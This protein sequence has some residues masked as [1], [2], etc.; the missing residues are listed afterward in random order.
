MTKKIKQKILMK[1]TGIKSEWMARWVAQLQWAT[2][3]I[4]GKTSLAESL[5]VG[6]IAGSAPLLAEEVVRTK[7]IKE[8]H[9]FLT[10]RIYYLNKGR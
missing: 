9:Q 2:S 5:T 7:D 3:F 1:V 4:A 8:N 6:M 10:N